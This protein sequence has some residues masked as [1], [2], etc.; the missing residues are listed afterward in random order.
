MT[1]RSPLEMAIWRSLA[2]AVRW[3]AVCAGVMYVLVILLALLLAGGGA[4]DWFVDALFDPLRF[5][6]RSVRAKLGFLDGPTAILLLWFFVGAVVGFV[7][8]MLS[9]RR[10]TRGESS[11]Q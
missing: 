10:R 8:S 5:A 4:P 7:H 9:W 1:Y 3:G 11:G 6:G 2:R